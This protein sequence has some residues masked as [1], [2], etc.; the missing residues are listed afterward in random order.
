MPSRFAR[1]L[2]DGVSG[3]K[4]HS[5]S[6]FTKVKIACC[7]VREKYEISPLCK[8]KC[9]RIEAKLTNN[10]IVRCGV[11]VCVSVCKIKAN[12]VSELPSST[13][14]LIANL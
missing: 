7:V 1:S 13:Q 11:F 9:D 4:I 5:I 8:S 14:K 10:N 3:L 12:C 2:A 6:E